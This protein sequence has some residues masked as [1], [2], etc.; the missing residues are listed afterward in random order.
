MNLREYYEVGRTRARMQ[1]AIEDA[2]MELSPDF[3]E[4]HDLL[5][6]ISVSLER[7]YEQDISDIAHEL[8]QLQEALNE[9]DATQ[10]RG[11][12]EMTLAK[13]DAEKQL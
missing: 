1:R 4:A 8:K 13:W 3:M 12:D 5:S 6:A 9:A 11:Y 7:K 10:E 2:I